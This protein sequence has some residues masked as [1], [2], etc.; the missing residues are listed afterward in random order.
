MPQLNGRCSPKS[1]RAQQWQGTGLTMGFM[2][3]WSKPV[4]DH[5][6]P[7]SDIRAHAVKVHS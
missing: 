5:G 4:S 6:M 2:V 1:G 3:I 7:K